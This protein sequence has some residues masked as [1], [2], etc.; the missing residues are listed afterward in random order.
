MLQ[1]QE[2][3]Y[4]KPAKRIDLRGE[5]FPWVLGICIAAYLLS[6]I[7]FSQHLE[8]YTANLRSIALAWE[9]GQLAT[10]DVIM[11]VITQYLYNTRVG[12][13]L[14]L[15]LIDVVFGNPGDAGFRGLVIVSFCLLLLCSVSVARHWGKLG[16][17]LGFAACAAGFIAVPGLVD[18]GAFFNDNVV[19][20]ALGIAALAVVSR[21]GSIRAC[22]ASGVLLGAAALCRTDALALC[23]AVAGFVWLQHGR[24][25]PLL[26]RGAATLVGVLLI[27]IVV[28]ALTGVTLISALHIPVAFVPPR[29]GILY[30]IRIFS[31]FIGAPA[32]A[33]LCIGAVL[34]FQERVRE[35]RDFRWGL[36]FFAYP[37]LIAGLAVLR[38]STEGRYIYPLLAPFYV[39]HAGRGF[40]YLA[41]L[42]RTPGWQRRVGA[43]LAAVLILICVIPPAAFVR[44]GPHSAVGRLWMPLLWFRWQ[45]SVAQSLHRIDDLAAIA[46]T[47]SQMLVLSTHFNDEFFLRLRLL[48]QGFQVKAAEDEFPGCQGGFSV[49]A[50]P[51]HRL[52][53]IRTENQYGLAEK[54]ANVVVRAVQIQRA[55]QCP[56]AWR[57][58]GAYLAF[59][60]EDVRSSSLPLD[61]MLFSSVIPRLP[62]APLLSTT[63]ELGSILFPNAQAN[64]PTTGAMLGE[65]RMSDI[66]VTPLTRDEL[67]SIKASADQMMADFNTDG[68]PRPFTYEDF[69][70]FY[71]ARP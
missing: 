40:E 7:L 54:I 68:E 30:R 32:L 3:V 43:A 37:A 1:Q 57:F 23:P 61:A 67:K 65:L 29:I 35:A 5:W 2:V 6:P 20:A 10:L 41:G 34:N 66:H 48:D 44:D 15:R 31:L 71:R 69:K 36:V 27:S 64:V 4:A 49:Y 70:A 63:F 13:I 21:S 16:G 28:Y 59:A 62:P 42:L 26:I 46:G 14:L 53:H 25:G 18:I 45:N 39:V 9:R 60:G 50:K 17:R 38:L 51:G 52:L 8:G 12:V 19:S 58:D 22:A 11:P 47:D 24:L 33:L 55:L 56:D